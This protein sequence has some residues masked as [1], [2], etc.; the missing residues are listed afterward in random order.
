MNQ[1]KNARNDLSR[2]NSE[3]LNKTK[4]RFKRE[5]RLILMAALVTLILVPIALTT[6]QTEDWVRVGE[7]ELSG[8]TWRTETLIDST[9]MLD[10]IWLSSGFSY[11]VVLLN[12]TAPVDVYLED[13]SDQSLEIFLNTT[14]L[15]LDLNTSHHFTLYLVY[16][17]VDAFVKIDNSYN[18]EWYH[19]DTVTVVDESVLNEYVKFLLFFYSAVVL[20]YVSDSVYL[21]G[22]RE[23]EEAETEEDSPQ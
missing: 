22:R 9:N 2:S 12:A 21:F 13:H 20:V 15:F 7:P 19:Y 4:L 11:T 17:G 3:K 16:T 8:H 5:V 1:G 14:D 23:N 18:S 6:S 10:R